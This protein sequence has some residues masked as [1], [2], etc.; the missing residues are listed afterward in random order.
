M[1]ISMLNLIK[2]EYFKIFKHKKNTALIISCIFFFLFIGFSNQQ[3]DQNYVNKKTSYLK[4]EVR[5]AS[6]IL[7]SLEHILKQ[8]G[9]KSAERKNLKKQYDFWD[10]ETEYSQL[11]LSFYTVKGNSYASDKIITDYTIKRNLNFIEGLEQGYTG[12]VFQYSNK[13]EEIKEL[14][15]EILIMQSLLQTNKEKLDAD[16]DISFLYSS[17]YEMNGWNYLT[18]LFDNG[19]LIYLIFI[20]LLIM[21]DLY[22]AEMEC[23]SYKMYMT[24]PYSRKKIIFAK[25]ITGSSLSIFII[26]ICMMTGFSIFSIQT[27]VSNS[28]YPYIAGNGTIEPCYIHFLKLILFLVCSVVFMNIVF[29]YIATFTSSISSVITAIACYFLCI[30]FIYNLF[31][32]SSPWI[33]QLPFIGFLYISELIKVQPNILPPLLINIAV[34]V[35]TTLLCSKRFINLD[36]KN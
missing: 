17:P 20:I 11:L 36:L 10:K 14:K 7:D 24:C 29:I 12:M 16:P 34:I 15:N 31:S 26:M 1:V 8:S 4:N 18:I 35:L 21:I 25:M 9:M 33:V 28:L 27:D 2:I 3:K 6:S 23:G 22:A 19:M 32:I 13:D 30:F 5:E